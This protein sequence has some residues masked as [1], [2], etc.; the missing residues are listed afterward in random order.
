MYAICTV[1]LVNLYL[2]YTV[3]CLLRVILVDEL[4]FKRFFVLECVNTNE[5]QNP[6]N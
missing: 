3:V 1:Y 2:T 4:F 5:P 6:I